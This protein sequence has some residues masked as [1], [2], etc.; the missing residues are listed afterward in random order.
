[1]QSPLDNIEA[2]YDKSKEYAETQMEL[3]R[4]KAIDK[5]STMISSLASRLIYIVI[6]LIG[7]FLLNIALGFW[8]GEIFGKVYYGFFCLAAFYF[9]VGLIVFAI[10][11]N[12]IG[13]PIRNALIDKFDK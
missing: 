10:S 12:S 3:F 6:F 13:N 11:K 8:L 1:M 7:L 5:A 2:L 9:I 4:L